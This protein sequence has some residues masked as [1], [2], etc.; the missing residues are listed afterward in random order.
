[1]IYG[2]FH[3]KITTVTP[4]VQLHSTFNGEDKPREFPFPSSM[5]LIISYRQNQNHP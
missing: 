4:H 2:K 3:V 5:M 1:M